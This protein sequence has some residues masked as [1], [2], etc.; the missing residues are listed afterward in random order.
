M[1]AMIQSL[2]ASVTALTAKSA[3]DGGGGGHGGGRD[4]KGGRVAPQMGQ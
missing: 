1:R 3:T 2:G 4:K